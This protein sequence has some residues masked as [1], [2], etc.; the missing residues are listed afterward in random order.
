MAGSAGI[1]DV[2]VV[3]DYVT[4]RLNEAGAP[5]SVLK[6]HKL[7]YYVQAWHLAFFGRPLFASSFQAWVHGPVSRPIYDRFKDNKSMY[8]RVLTDD[9]KPSF[10]LDSM[11]KAARRHVDTVL[12]SY[13]EYTDTQLEELTHRE[14]PWKDARKGYAPS[15]R[16]EVNIKNEDNAI[17]LCRK[18]EQSLLVR[19]EAEANRRPPAAEREKAGHR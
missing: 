6:L 1:I 9:I 12:E 3:C 18:A 5:P 8:S 17:V 7:L 11:P 13:A 2:N 14:K 19:N 15:D 10:D 16:C 4:V